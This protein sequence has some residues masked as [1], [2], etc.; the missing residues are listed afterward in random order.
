MSAGARRVLIAMPCVSWIYTEAMLSFFGLWR[1]ELP[2]GT[3]WLENAGGSSL[4]AKRNRLA[5]E[6]CAASEF[7]HLLFLDSDM[8]VPPDLVRR[9]LAH[10]R[11]VVGALCAVRHPPYHAYAGRQ[12]SADGIGHT[13]DHCFWPLAPGQGLQPVDRIGTAALLVARRVFATVSEPWF[14]PAIDG[15]DGEDMSFC[16]QLQRAG[17]ALWAD[18]DLDVGHLDVTALRPAMP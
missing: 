1:T 14:A 17:I 8:L 10:D 2:H 3:A 9:L 18:T 7:T 11:D 13:S 4:A 5:R 12:T 15:G 16:E 6:F